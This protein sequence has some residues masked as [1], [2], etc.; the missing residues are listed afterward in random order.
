MY[1]WFTAVFYVSSSKNSERPNSA[2]LINHYRHVSY[3]VNHTRL[4][5][6]NVCRPHYE[7]RLIDWV[8]FNVPLYL[9]VRSSHHVKSC[10]K[11]CGAIWRWNKLLQSIS[12]NR[13][14]IHT[15]RRM[16]SRF[17]YIISNGLAC[18]V[19]PIF[20][21]NSSRKNTSNS[22]N[23]SVHWIDYIN[24]YGGLMKKNHIF[25]GPLLVLISLVCTWG[26]NV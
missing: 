23:L 24:T 13:Q 7:E 2:F 21:T 16:S 1:F 9:N 18:P 20:Y 5:T 22:R 11:R 26:G 15:N 25:K 4:S 19:L 12:S 8:E 6:F 17:R 3:S 10:L 14:K